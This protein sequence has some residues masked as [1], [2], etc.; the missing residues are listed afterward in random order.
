MIYLEW[1]EESMRNLL[2]V[3]KDGIMINMIVIIKIIII[4]SNNLHLLRVLQWNNHN[5][6]DWIH[7]RS[8]LISVVIAALMGYKIINQRLFN[9]KSLKVIKSAQGKHLFCI[10]LGISMIVKLMNI[11]KHLHSSSRNS[12]KHHHS[13]HLHCLNQQLLIY[14]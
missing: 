3:K 8:Y 5:L 14:L 2:L 1:V 12:S 7:L 10:I 6:L 13:G 11:L 9:I 4:N